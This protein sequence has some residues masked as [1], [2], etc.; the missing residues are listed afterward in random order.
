MELNTYF[1]QYWHLFGLIFAL[2]ALCGV[3][4]NILVDW[5]HRQGYSEGYTWLM[6]VV[7]V[8]I[9]LLAAATLF[10]LTGIGLLPILLTFAL[11]AAAGTPMALGDLARYLRARQA[12]EKPTR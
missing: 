1:S 10:Q 11:F 5:L 2:T 7:G 4:Y 3:A 12:L 6:V 8:A 9:V